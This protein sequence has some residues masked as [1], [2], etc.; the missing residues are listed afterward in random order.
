MN[1]NSNLD[2][3]DKWIPHTSQP[4]KNIGWA[5]FFS[6]NY[7]CKIIPSGEYTGSECVVFK[8]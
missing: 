7:D 1:W 2:I 6:A 4:Y 8:F 5:I 3:N